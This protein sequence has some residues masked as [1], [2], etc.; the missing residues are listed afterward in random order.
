MPGC[1]GVDALWQMLGFYLGWLGLPGP[2]R[3]LSVGDVKF[4]GEVVPAGKLLRYHL[5]VKRVIKRAFT[6][7]IADGFAEL[8]GNRVYEANALR[9]GLF[10]QGR[11]ET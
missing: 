2:G 6:L 7:G 1:L 9:V 8:D 5:D 4:S 11:T 10:P 3:A